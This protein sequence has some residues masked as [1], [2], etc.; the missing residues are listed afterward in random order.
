MA[1]QD[2]LKVVDKS[3]YLRLCGGEGG[4]FGKHDPRD[5]VFASNRRGVLSL[6]MVQKHDSNIQFT[7]QYKTVKSKS[8]L[9]L[10]PHVA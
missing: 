10:I 8:I 9:L 5:T 2:E 6:E 7:F 3:A 4:G 1:T